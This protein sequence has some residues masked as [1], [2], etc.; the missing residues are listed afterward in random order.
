[1][2]LMNGGITMKILWVVAIML[3]VMQSVEA[4][5]TRTPTSDG[6][7]VSSHTLAAS[8][9]IDPGRY[10]TTVTPDFNGEMAKRLEKSVGAIAGLSD[11][12]ADSTAS[13]LTF[14]VIDGSR[15]RVVDIQ[16]VVAKTH[17]NGVMTAPVMQG[18]LTPKPG[19]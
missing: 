8:A 10:V 17:N 6:S 11:V 1:M 4:A 5:D 14:T 16:K 3:G 13:T 9:V 12:K 15:A 7:G 19:L 18:T 2:D